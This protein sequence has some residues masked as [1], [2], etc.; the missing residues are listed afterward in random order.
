MV[1]KLAYLGQL[2]EY[3]LRTEVG[4]L[5][6]ISTAVDRP[7]PAGAKLSLTLANHG[8]VVVP[9]AGA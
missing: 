1:R 3:T 8:V 4:E 6:V 9:P 2:M 7:L 5:F